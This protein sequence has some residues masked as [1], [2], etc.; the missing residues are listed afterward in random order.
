MLDPR[1]YHILS[2]G[3]FLGLTFFQSFIAG[4]V[5]YKTLPR[6]LF[7][8]LQQVTFPIFFALQTG[9]SAI[10][11]MTFPGDKLMNTS[12]RINT[13]IT[14]LWSTGDNIWTSGT[15]IAVMLL[16]SAANLLVFG[17]QTTKV[18]KERHHQGELFQVLFKI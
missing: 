14:G 15:P 3:T 4:P 12:A 9:L 18:M 11:A 6:P 17:P 16:S 2:Y 1:A 10:I 7:A 5:A 13:G 8:R